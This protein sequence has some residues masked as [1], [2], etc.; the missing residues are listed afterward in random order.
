MLVAAI[1]YCMGDGATL[2]TIMRLIAPGA[3]NLASSYSSPSCN[4]VLERISGPVLTKFPCP[5]PFWNEMQ[6][7]GGPWRPI[8]SIGPWFQ[9]TNKG[10]GPWTND[11]AVL[12]PRG[13]HLRRR[14]ACAPCPPS[15][16]SSEC[17]RSCATTSFPPPRKA[18]PPLLHLTVLSM[19][20]TM[21]I[22][23][24]TNALKNW[25]MLIHSVVIHIVARKI[26]HDKQLRI[27]K[28][29]TL[30]KNWQMPILLAVKKLI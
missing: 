9:P 18:V 27:L 17:G 6:C 22:E 11:I 28:E 5:L 12:Q 24:L 1:I 7:W 14:G 29:Q 19:A 26:I 21:S 16:R 10:F 3:S 4:H 13:G 2:W 15:S 20:Q 25:Q 23:E 30:L 8:K